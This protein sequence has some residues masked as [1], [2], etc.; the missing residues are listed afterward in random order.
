VCDLVGDVP[1]PAE[2]R[3]DAGIERAV[4]VQDLHRTAHPVAMRCCVDGRHAAHVDQ[5]ID[6]PLAAQRATHPGRGFPRV[7]GVEG[8]RHGDA[9]RCKML[10]A[11]SPLEGSLLR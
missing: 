10:A 4:Q 5:R 2:A 7:V 3:R 8:E 6:V 1:F 11:A 9:S